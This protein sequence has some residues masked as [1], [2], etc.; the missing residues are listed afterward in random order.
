MELKRCRECGHEV[1]GL[2]RE[3]PGCGAPWPG[4]QHYNRGKL[5]SVP[6]LLRMAGAVF[7]GNAGCAIIAAILWLF[8]AVLLGGAIFGGSGGL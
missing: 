1:S 8:A 6:S 5:N 2:A 7:I 3:C 4:D